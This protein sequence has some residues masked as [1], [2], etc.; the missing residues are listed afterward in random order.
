MYAKQVGRN[1]FL[2]DLE[3]GGFKALI[4]SYVLRGE[5]Q[6]FIIETGPSSSISNLLA[7]LSE[8]NIKPEEV[9]YVAVTHVHIDHAG[10]AGKLLK[11]LPNAKVLVHKKGVAHLVDPSKLWTASKETLGDVA[12]MFEKPLP[13]PEERIV[14]VSDGLMFD[15]GG[16]LK[17]ET[18][19][20]PGHASH[21]VAYYERLD[22]GV[23]PGDSAGAFLSDFNL[24]FPTTPPP[25]R[26]DIALISLDKLIKLNP[27]F[28]FYSHFGKAS[29]AVRR[30]RDYQVQIKMWLGI[31]Q[32]GLRRGESP[33]AIREEI[34]REDETIRNSLPELKENPV[35]RRTL[36]E[37]SVL[38]FIEFVRNPQI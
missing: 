4:G 9:D 20:T 28:L 12:E 27:R 17:V 35:N 32:D 23:F 2:I 15:L 1:L 38:G 21:N 36:L 31:V 11:K 25:F 37:N 30:L 26:P 13:I 34:F 22:E 33:E 24:V 14:A 19:E 5:K 10:G 18:V 6:T 8:L 29:D 3:S 16:G 7:G